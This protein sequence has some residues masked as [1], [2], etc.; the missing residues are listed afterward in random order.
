[1][2]AYKPF[3][4]SDIILSPFEVN[5]FFTFQGD[6]AVTSS[7]IDRFIGK[8]IPL[9]SEGLWVSGSNPTGDIFIQ[10]Q[11]LVYR[12]I[13][14]LYYSNFIGNNDGAPMGLAVFETDGTITGPGYTP[15]YYNYLPNTLNANRFF[16]TGSNEEIFLCFQIYASLCTLQS[17]IC[18]FI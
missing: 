15:N 16:P 3:T 2:S 6:T 9:N 7:G 13:R 18:K 8:N 14:E 1:M 5:K 4:T 11:F 10:D 12:S 17:I